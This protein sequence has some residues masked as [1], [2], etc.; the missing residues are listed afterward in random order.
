MTLS[1]F[2]AG[3]SFAANFKSPDIFIL[4]D[5]QLTFGS[6]EVFFEFFADIKK[7]CSPDEMQKENLKQLGEMSVGVLGVRAT[8]LD[9][10]VARDGKP[11]GKICDVDPTWHVNARAFGILK[12]KERK[13]IQIGQHEPFR[14]CERNK[15]A[16]EVMFR[17]KYYDPKLFIMSFLGN[18]AK[19][20]AKDKEAA[21]QDVVDTMQQ[22]PDGVPCIF[23]TTAPA[24]KKKTL[25]LRLRAQ[26]NIRDAFMEAGSR[27]SFVEG[28]TPET[29]KLNLGNKRY[30]K[31][32]KK[33]RVKDPFHPKPRAIKKFFSV[34][35]GDICSA[36]FSQIRMTS[37]IQIGP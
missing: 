1:A 25:D 37:S 29:V 32:D 27:C 26:N 15:S 21:K 31:L 30:F 35:M 34:E 19:R 3:P 36:I 11:K 5:S 6:G 13:Y 9:S 4:G 7:H 8:S 12:A 33:G 2:V 28:H 24:Y 22:I 20:W 23:M 10:W 16:F 17:D 14:F 18:S